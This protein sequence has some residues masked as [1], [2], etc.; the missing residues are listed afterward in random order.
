MGT[1]NSSPMNE[2]TTYKAQF[3]EDKILVDYFGHKA[4]GF[5][6][7]VGAYDGVRMSNSY[8]F[9]HLGWDGILVEADPGLADE[10]RSS[11]PRATVINCAVVSPQAPPVV[12]FRVSDE[13]KS[14]SSL[15]FNK[16]RRKEVEQL[17]GDFKVSEI[18][19]PGKTLDA[20]FAEQGIAR[21]DFL[22]IDVEGHEW[23]VLQGFTISR[24]KPEIVIIERNTLLPDLRIAGYMFRN[25]Y[26]YLRT[27]GVNDWFGPP[28]APS[29][30]R[31]RNL[32][33][34]A[35]TFYAVRPA[36]LVYRGLRKRL[37][38]L[39]GRSPAPR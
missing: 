11:R 36:R 18:S 1:V 31:A 5:Y 26:Y 25:G 37:K 4:E 15:S 3:G 8:H 27:T 12:T 6:V 19:V 33:Y 13:W 38:R 17:T 20:I 22:T 34:F 7:E 2:Q 14:L 39:L 9:E 16:S 28:P 21:V 23:D 24:W 29:A 35:A 10:C 32:A 30:S